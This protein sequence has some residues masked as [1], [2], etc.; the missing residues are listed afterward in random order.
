MIKNVI[1]LLIFLL[2]IIIPVLLVYLHN[3]KTRKR[4]HEVALALNEV[5]AGT[6]VIATDGVDEPYMFLS[7]EIPSE[8][9]MKKKRVMLKVYIDDSQKKHTL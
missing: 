5:Y 1:I 4:L 7:L 8:E 6:L 9:L 3:R 2:A